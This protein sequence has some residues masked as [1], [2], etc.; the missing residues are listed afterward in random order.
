MTFSRFLKKAKPLNY[1][2]KGFFYNSWEREVPIAGERYS[3]AGE[4]G[5]GSG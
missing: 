2:F 3:W 1:S 4:I 5:A